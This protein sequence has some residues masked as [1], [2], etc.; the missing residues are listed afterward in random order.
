MK[1]KFFVKDNID[2]KIKKLEN[3]SNLILIQQLYCK[4][5]LKTKMDD[6]ITLI[7]ARVFSVYRIFF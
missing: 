2:C 1:C 6:K 4:S 5:S 7:I 3:F